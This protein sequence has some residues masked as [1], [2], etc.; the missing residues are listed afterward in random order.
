[1]KI[2]FLE[3]HPMWIYGL[4]NGFRDAGH[5]VL[6]SGPLTKE[7]LPNMIKEFSPDLIFS[8]GWGP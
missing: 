2:L 6:V 1:M 3:S 8:M 7:N 4:P 5:Q